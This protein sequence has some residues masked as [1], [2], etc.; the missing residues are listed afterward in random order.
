M[1][2]SRPAESSSLID[3]LDSRPS[4]IRDRHN[5]VP[6]LSISAIARWA[7]PRDF[8]SL[9]RR[10]PTT[11]SVG[12]RIDAGPKSQT[13]LPGGRRNPRWCLG[14]LRNPRRQ[15][16]MTPMAATIK[17]VCNRSAVAFP[18]RRSMSRRQIRRLA[19]SAEDAPSA[20]IADHPR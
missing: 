10:L 17:C 19:S 12:P 18:A 9:D 8:A 11:Q 16:S 13:A 2:R 6:L 5:P 20:R 7:A 14:R 1:L 3:H 4:P 15:R